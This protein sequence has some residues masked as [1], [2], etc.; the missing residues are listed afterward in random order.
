MKKVVVIGSSNTDMA[1]R[2]KNI[3]SG[4]ETVLGKGFLMTQGGKGANQAVAAARAGAKVVF[5]SKLGRDVFGDKALAG[6]KKEKIVTKYVSRDKNAPSGIALIVIDEH[7]ENSIVVVSGANY[8]LLPSDIKK[9]ERE[10]K[11]AA[12]VVLQQEIS[13][14]TAAYSVDLAYKYNV[15]VI[16]NPAP[17]RKI[18]K[19]ILK[20]IFLLNP[21]EKEAE[22]LTGIKISNIKSARKAAARIKA[23]GVKNVIITLGKRGVF[24]AGNGFEMRAPAF[25]VKAVDTTAAGDAFTGGF[26]FA[27][28]K[29]KEFCECVRFGMAAAAL[30]VTKRGAQ[31]SLPGKRQIARFLSRQK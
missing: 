24:A 5:I 29:K 27:L 15:P 21:N 8:R 9:A 6:F 31:S 14:Q 10:I 23:N 19:T 7:A 11:N 26:A 16:L 22:F 4:G 3:P 17:A 30:A 28:A 18:S 12:C 25:K 13:E 1:V 20:K 2:T